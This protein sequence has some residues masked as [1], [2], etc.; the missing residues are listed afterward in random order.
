MK[1]K[2]SL[3]GFDGLE[4][5]LVEIEQ[6]SGRTVSGKNAVRRGMRKA[7]GRIEARAKQL[8][9]VEEG[10]LRESITT[11][12]AKAQR[13]RG[14]KRFKRQT[15]VEVLTGPTG[16]EEGGNAAW[17]EFG[18]VKMSANPYMRPAADAEGQA[19]VDEVVE[20]IGAEVRKTAARARKK[21]ESKR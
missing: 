19:V 18:T 6:L 16:R 12:N 2:A 15:G 17:Q 5:A 14:S 8:A 11:K 4:A 20:I 9:P 1:L 7:M 21:A 13:E 10:D 3:K